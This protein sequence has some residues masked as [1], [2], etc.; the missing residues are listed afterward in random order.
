MKY[1]TTIDPVY[2]HDMHLKNFSVFHQSEGA[3]LSPAYDLLN[4]NLVNPGDKEEMGLTL[5][6]KKNKIKLADFKVLANNLGIKEKVYYNSFKLFSSKNEE[7]SELIDCS[8][9]DAKMKKNYKQIWNGKQGIF[10]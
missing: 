3:V 5:N 8:F 9:L 7:V 2:P 6:G 4:V 1:W 10:G